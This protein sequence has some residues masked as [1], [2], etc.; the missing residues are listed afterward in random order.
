M[1]LVFLVSLAVV[2]KLQF[3]WD[4]FS[5]RGAK[6]PVDCD[7]YFYPESFIGVIGFSLLKIIVL[8]GVPFALYMVFYQR[9][10]SQ[11]N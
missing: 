6:S 1:N 4:F 11:F 8:M 9:N 7:K 2:A 5:Y 3:A 10:K